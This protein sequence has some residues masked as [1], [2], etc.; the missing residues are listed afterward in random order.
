MLPAIEALSGSVEVPLSK[1]REPVDA[2]EGLTPEDMRELLPNPHRGQ[3]AGGGLSS[4]WLLRNP[5]HRCNHGRCPVSRNGAL[6]VRCLAEMGAVPGRKE[7]K[8][9]GL[10]FPWVRVQRERGTMTRNSKRLMGEA[11]EL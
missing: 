6:V 9:K 3:D 7:C 5:G 2:A 4:P 1:V 10:V 8:Q 11:R